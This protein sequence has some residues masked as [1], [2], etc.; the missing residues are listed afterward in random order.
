M[1]D[2]RILSEAIRSGSEVAFEAFFRAEFCN[3][4]FFVNRYG[5]SGNTGWNH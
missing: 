5:I 1:N 3:V 4:A 2:L